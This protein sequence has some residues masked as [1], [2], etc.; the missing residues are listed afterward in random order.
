MSLLAELEELQRC[1]EADSDSEDACNLAAPTADSETSEKEDVSSFANRNKG[2]PTGLVQDCVPRHPLHAEAVCKTSDVKEGKVV[3]DNADVVVQKFTTLSAA[4]SDKTESAAQVSTTQTSSQESSA[5]KG[6]TSKSFRQEAAAVEMVTMKNVLP[7]SGMMQANV[8]RGLADGKVSREKLLTDVCT[9]DSPSK[10]LKISI[11]RRDEL[12]AP[13]KLEEVKILTRKVSDTSAFDKGSTNTDSLPTGISKMDGRSQ[14]SMSKTLPVSS[15]ALASEDTL[16]FEELKLEGV[17]DVNRSPFQ[18]KEDPS[19]E[20]INVNKP[21]AA[22]RQAQAIVSAT[23]KSEE[24]KLPNVPLKVRASDAGPVVSSKSENES[25]SPLRASQ[26]IHKASRTCV[27]STTNKKSSLDSDRHTGGRVQPTPSSSVFSADSKLSRLEEVRISNNRPVIRVLGVLPDSK[28]S[29]NKTAGVSVSSPASLSI[30]RRGN[31]PRQG[32]PANSPPGAT[33]RNISFET[34]SLVGQLLGETQPTV[35]IETYKQKNSKQLEK[36]KEG[37]N[38][39]KRK[40]SADAGSPCV[41]TASSQYVP[42]TSVPAV[43]RKLPDVSV[44]EGNV[45][46][47]SEC[48]LQK[49]MRVHRDSEGKHKQEFCT[50]LGL[51]TGMAVEGSEAVT[52]GTPALRKRRA[53][54]DPVA[55][56]DVN[57]NKGLSLPGGKRR[58]LSSSEISGL[59]E[60]TLS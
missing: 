3:L 53:T 10:D 46:V 6:H 22:A 30:V 11:L 52:V 4:N 40:L 36:D 50:T 59:S 35:V 15:P 47:D 19:K 17:A 26:S 32:G 25:S 12:K 24:A 37:T 54:S 38:L 18:T 29:K 14:M 44:M 31:I 21:I 41:S 8:S 28:K 57:K 7:K 9:K 45:P 23:S 58:K 1:L 55:S 27:N 16:I 51:E 43:K 34:V 2:E 13:S 42:E 60:Q 49:N 33:K 5:N 56:S 39:K 48:Q 20:Q